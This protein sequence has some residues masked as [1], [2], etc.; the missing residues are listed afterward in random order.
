MQRTYLSTTITTYMIDTYRIRKLG[1]DK[2]ALL[3]ILA[4]GLLTARFV[5]ALKS[6]IVLSEPIELAHAGLSLSMPA[7]NGWEN[8]TE[9]VYG[10]NALTL[11]SD[12][13]LASGRPTARAY[14]R[15]LLAP[16][17]TTPQ[18]WFTEKAS[19][20][21]GSI[22]ETGQTRTDTLTID[23]AHIQKSEVLLTTFVGTVEL[24]GNRQLDIEVREITGDTDLAEFT[25]RHVVNS[26]DFE[27]N[28]LIEA[29]AEVVTQIKSKGLSSFLSN[30]NQ[31]T[32]FLIKDSRKRSV[33]Y[34]MDVVVDS[35]KEDELNIE[36][37]GLFYMRDRNTYEQ[38][39]SFESNNSFDIFVWK[40]ETHSQTHRSRTEIILEEAGLM[41]VRRSDTAPP[42]SSIYLGPTAIPDI[43]LD[44]VLRQMLDS[45]KTEI[46][47]D[48]IGTDGK[49]TPAFISGIEKENDIAADDE[50]AY[51]LKLELLD[52]R[53]F[54]E[55]IYLDDQ[56]QIYRRILR[57]KDV[58][59]AESASME[60]IMREFPEQAEYTLRKN[61]MLE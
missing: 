35:G 37:A 19:Q 60:D 45:S 51:V 55:N 8:E 16:R 31:Q 54:S 5:V 20:I 29:G 40:S 7:G 34:T 1:G 56:K 23:W 47:V 46:V 3:G 43:F 4:V 15:Y 44:Y 25:F 52:G 32:F 49:V 13:A 53:G 9:W 22:V 17:R 18:I 11:S 58:Y 38:V 10:E 39:G 2:I 24:P 26:L 57:Q 27:D 6:A 42:E 12:F 30:Q 41:T 28:R 33:G 36:A 59:V 21:D 50:A 14:C 48:M 61:R